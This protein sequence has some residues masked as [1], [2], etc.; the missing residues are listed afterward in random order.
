M[1]NLVYK[2]E[3]VIT[4]ATEPYEEG[5]SQYAPYDKSAIELAI[6]ERENRRA[7]AESKRLDAANPYKNNSAP[8]GAAKGRTINW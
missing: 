6:Q 1:V 7:E 4:G 2:N 8:S 5:V 3:F